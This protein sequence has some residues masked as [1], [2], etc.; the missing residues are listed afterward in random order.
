MP[1]F[2][3]DARYFG[4]CS[5]AKKRKGRSV[6]NGALYGPQRRAFGLTVAYEA[7]R[8]IA[9]DPACAEQPDEIIG[10][11]YC[12]AVERKK[13]VALLQACQ[14]RRTTR[15]DPIDAYSLRACPKRQR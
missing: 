5:R 15:L 14:C 3:G 1:P 7:N 10:A 12:R 8:G 13:Q 9:P 11:H 4:A 6:F 2:P